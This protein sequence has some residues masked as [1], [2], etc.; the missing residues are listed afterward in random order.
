MATRGDDHTAALRAKVSKFKF[1][2]FDKNIE[3]WRYYIQR[4]QLELA[5]Q[6]L[7]GD[8]NNEQVARRNL[9]LK[10]IGPEIYR[11]VVDHFDPKAVT[12]VSYDDII[13]FLTSYF[14]P[15]TSYLAERAK[16]GQCYRKDEQTVS[17]FISEL[18]SLA[19]TCK[20][21]QSQEE[22]IRDQFLL[23]LR[24]PSMQEDLFS[25]HPEDNASLAAIETSSLL[26]ESAQRQRKTLESSQTAASAYSSQLSVSKLTQGYSKK[27]TGNKN[28]VKN[29]SKDTTTP[30]RRTIDVIKQCIRCG[31][32]KHSFPDKCPAIK[33]R[34]RACNDVGHWDCVCIKSGNAITKGRK[35]DVKAIRATDETSDSDD[36]YEDNFSF[37]GH[38]SAISDERYTITVMINDQE[39]VME[40][41]TAAARTVIGSHTWLQIGSPQLMPTATLT[42]YP[43]FTIPMMG[44]A[45]VT[46]KIGTK[47]RHLHVAVTKDSGIPLFGKD[48]MEAFDLRPQCSYVLLKPSPI[49]FTNASN[50]SSHEVGVDTD[51]QNLMN[52][53]AD[54][55]DDNVS[56][57]ANYTVTLC[58][59]DNAQ[60]IKFRSRPVPFAMRQAADVEIDRL[61]K[62]G[63]IE[64][65]DPTV[66]PIEWATPVV[67]VPKPNG[68]LRLCG[69]FK[70]TINKYLD[71]HPHPLPRFE[72]VVNKLSGY[73]EFS[74]ID[75]KDAYL[76]LPVAEESR[77]YLVIS[78]HK[79]FFRYT[80]LPFGINSAPGIFQAYM[81]TLFEG[82]DGVGWFLDDIATG[83]CNRQQHLERLRTVFQILRRA[84]LRTQQSKLSL[85]KKEVKLLG[86]RVSKEGIHPT[87]EGV[88][89]LKN[90]PRPTNVKQL[91][92]FLGSINFYSKFIPNLQSTC[93]PLNRLLQDSVKWEW[94]NE[95]ENI[96][97]ALKSALSSEDTLVHYNPSLP[98]VMATD[99][100]EY[101]VG[102]ILMHRYPNGQLRPITAA[103]RS[104]DVS[105]QRYA[106]IDR[107]GLAIMFGLAKFHMYVYG[108]NFIIQTDHRPLERIFGEHAEIPKMAVSRLTRWA[109]T[110]SSYDYCIEYK[111]GKDNCVADML[112][113]LPLPNKVA[114][115]IECADNKIVCQIRA[116]HL[117]NLA[118]S[119]TSLRKKTLSDP[120]LSKIIA[121]TQRGWPE[122]KQLQPEL[123]PFFEKRQEIS[124]EENMLLWQNRI[125]V[126]ATLRASVLAYMHEG[127]CGVVATK[128]IAR[129][130]VWWP[131]ID[132]DIEHLIATCVP[133]QQH[134][135]KEPE[136]PINPWNV[137]QGPWERIH[138]DFTGPYEGLQWF[139]VIDAFSR[140]VEIYPMKSATSHGVI[141]FLR[142]LFARFGICRTIVSDNGSQF[143]S[144]EFET[145]CQ[146]NG[147]KHIKSTPYHSRTNGMVERVIQTFKRHFNSNK[148]KF[149]D[150][151]HRLQVFLFWYRISTHTSTQRSPAELFLG[152]KPATVLDRMKPDVM[153]NMD[154]ATLKQKMNHD[155]HTRERSFAPD[156]T[157]WTRRGLDEMWK[158]GVVKRR[159]GELSYVVEVDGRPQRY[160]ADHM[161][162]RQ[163]NDD[164]QVYDSE[165]DSCD[166]EDDIQLNPSDTTKQPV[167]QTV[168]TRSYPSRV[169]KQPKRFCDDYDI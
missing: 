80:R 4:F 162:M 75:L 86:F 18:R 8:E 164:N 37:I 77:K 101:G 130:S 111:P 30:E 78:T 163:T 11:L 137:A 160:H 39:I 55:F 157:V 27:F 74:I 50:T 97:I 64:H 49:P 116:I 105:E 1:T 100:S 6:G 150:V 142:T 136:T 149:P 29:L 46:V 161:R 121:Y 52:E 58:I 124:H 152:R 146:V 166:E 89:S 115:E 133:C 148:S 81:D 141:T 5:I 22:R 85:L 15:T 79:G 155:R 23:G 151:Q 60:P 88:E 99:A 95:D 135:G 102:A 43:A 45:D 140:W 42:A 169:R 36:V 108:R 38:V 67:Y 59:K 41:D 68:Q 53:Y 128:S 63:I 19:V 34:C 123:I 40:Y 44:E 113:R 117:E 84:H 32:D 24:N 112:S 167:V 17:Q 139:V 132:D 93:A 56:S 159:T 2:Q 91:R 83:G 107:E 26:I 92:S 28:K 73:T 87:K 61:L 156:D 16:F 12:D 33:S 134:R 25:K 48:W 154:H 62:N 138:I 66:T 120:I 82:V 168:T 47:V 129:M 76:Q 165:H 98:L 70:V 7:D 147:V 54:I 94:T 31:N 69:D 20:F 126:P 110:L 109:L 104:L 131:K 71:A 145:F 3:E 21:G 158:A 118:L 90:L 13:T 9:L 103:S 127:H 65:V 153:G 51:L 114:S 35:S 14:K 122:K 143:I 125:I 72:E 119:K 106:P 10:W 57:V 144:E 96:F